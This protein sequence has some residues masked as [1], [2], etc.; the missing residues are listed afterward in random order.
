MSRVSKKD[1]MRH[2]HMRMETFD[3]A[4]FL[5]YKMLLLC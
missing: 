4:M 5:L 3:Q 2:G 1:L